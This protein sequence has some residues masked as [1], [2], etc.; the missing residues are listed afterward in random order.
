MMDH[1]EER[2]RSDHWSLCQHNI[3]N[4]L[5]KCW[6]LDHSPEDVNHVIGL[7]EVNAFEVRL[8]HGVG[9][10]VF[11]LLAKLSHGCVSNC[12]Y[13]NVGGGS[14]ME[15]RAT[16]SIQ[17]GEEILDHYVSPL[18]NTVKRTGNTTDHIFIS[19]IIT[20]SH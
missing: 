12:R 2:R 9:R 5:I 7:I 20:Q 1:E 19:L 13:V 11:P 10:G 4:Y 8:E 14:V 16:V 15:C 18:E 17:Q 3:V 6:H